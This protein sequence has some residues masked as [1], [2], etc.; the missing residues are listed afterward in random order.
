MR[1]TYM[2]DLKQY[3]YVDIN[4]ENIFIRFKNIFSLKIPINEVTKI[5]RY[6]FK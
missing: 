6:L 5:I 4:D 2:D 1:R 3:V